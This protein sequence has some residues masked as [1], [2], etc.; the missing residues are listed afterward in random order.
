MSQKEKKALPKKAKKP[1]LEP[2]QKRNKKTKGSQIHWWNR[3]GLGKEKAF[4]VD[5][6]SML[7]GSGMGI[8]LVLQ[9]LEEDTRNKSMKKIIGQITDD[10]DSGSS[11][12][13]ALDR[14]RMLSQHIVALI[15]IG[16]KSGRLQ[17]NLILISEQQSKDRLFKSRI[18]SA[19]LYPVIV[20]IVAFVSGIGISWFILPRIVGIFNMIDTDVPLLTRI[21]IKIGEIFVNYGAILVPGLMLTMIVIV[22]FLFILPKTKTAGQWLLFHT[23]I[24]KKMILEIELSRFGF[25]L[26]ILLNAGLPIVDALD[27]L[28]EATTFYNYRKLYIHLRDRIN[29]GSSFMP[30]FEE[31]KKSNKMVP[32]PIQHMIETGAKSGTLADSLLKI[33]AIYEA[34]TEITTKSLTTVLEPI[35]LI[36]IGVGVLILALAI[37]TPIY[38]LIGSF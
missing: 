24:I 28:Q 20:I 2:E 38:G 14:S 18:R 29:E 26:G 35:L 1:G 32:I 9:S 27:S 36:I 7:L 4:F 33:G 31:I 34:K 25:I 37:I 6:L 12:S 21:L 8:D 23:P 17:E 16:E 11:I 22:F 5:N 19:M 15:R 30:C 10:I 3:V 13:Q